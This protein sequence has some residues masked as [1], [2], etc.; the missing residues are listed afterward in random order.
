MDTLYLSSIKK[1]ASEEDALIVYGDEASFRQSP[2]L[3]Q[4]WA[5]INSQLKIPTTGQRNTQK[6][7]GAIAIPTGKFEYRIQEDY[8][9]YKTYV[10]FLGDLVVPRFY[11]KGHR[12]FLIQDNASYHKKPETYEW[13][14]ANRKYVEVFNLPRYQPELNAI[15]RIWHHVRMYA[16]HNR[17]HETVESLRC[18]LF[19]SLSNIQVFPQSIVN[20]LHPY[21]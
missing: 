20:Y 8:F 16:T 1:K 21:F 18:A 10:E 14:T 15:E 9:N 4:T 19:D 13:F 11:R 12:I 7:L 17:F 6:I 2:T 3:Y 5:P